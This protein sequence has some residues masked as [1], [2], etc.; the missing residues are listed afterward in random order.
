MVEDDA[1][2]RTAL[3]YLLNHHGWRASEAA[4]VSHGL[5]LLQAL[6]PDILILDLMLPDG[7]GIE[8]LKLIRTSGLKVRVAVLT[9]VGDPDVL[10][11]VRQ[12]VPN[13]VF[14]K[15]VSIPALMEWL[16]QARS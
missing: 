3:R 2:S 5:E 9:G 14:R 7:D 1:A 15:P 16:E 4:T 6:R 12:L 10:D 11:A 8:I 13:A